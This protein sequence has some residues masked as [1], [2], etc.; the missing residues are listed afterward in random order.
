MASSASL[1]IALSYN[2]SSDPPNYEEA[3]GRPINKKVTYSFSQLSFNSMILLPPLDFHDS[4]PLYHIE[5]SM[6]C[7]IPSSFIT[8]IKRGSERGEL[9]GDFEQGITNKKST[10]FFLDTEYISTE[11]MIGK[12][13]YIWFPKDLK[14]RL[15]WQL[16]PLNGYLQCY[17]YPDISLML[18]VSERV[19]LATYYPAPTLRRRSGGQ[20]ILPKIE[21]EPQGQEYFDGIIMSLLIMERK[22]LSP[23]SS[24]QALF[25]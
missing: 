6:N 18:K 23:G 19:C 1:P 2:P 21:V 11:I 17:K 3:Q 10:V 14:R 24:D 16:N 8:T 25:S 4:R 15:V 7:F 20:V 5:I 22:R 9:I 13:T 12:V